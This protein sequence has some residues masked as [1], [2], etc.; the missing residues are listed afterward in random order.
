MDNNDLIIALAW[1]ETMVRNAGAW[2]EGVT[3]FLKFS[4]NG[5]YKAGH[6]AVVIIDH[7]SGTVKYFDFGRYHTPLG[8]GR[9]RD[10]ETDPDLRINTKA[11]FDQSG[12]ILNVEEILIE[13]KNNPSTNGSGKLLA[14][15]YQGI[16][17]SKAFSKAKELQDMEG[18]PY[19]PFVING[20]NCSRF[21]A[22]VARGGLKLSY[23]KISLKMPYTLT[24]TP[25]SNVRQLGG[26]GI[27]FKVSEDEVNRLEN[28]KRSILNLILFK[29]PKGLIQSKIKT[30]LGNG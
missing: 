29:Y 1:P 21:V 5:Y 22:E 14:G 25:I 3:N 20:T 13:L 16:S 10:E 2:Y 23:K 9:V 17:F 6:A 28:R 12:K 24:P 19:G 18:I 11:K 8:K 30:Q 26:E 4:I 7:K 15:V 27:F